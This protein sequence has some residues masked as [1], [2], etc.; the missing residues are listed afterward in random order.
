MSHPTCSKNKRTKIPGWSEHVKPLREDAMFWHSIWISSGSPSTGTV[1]VIRRRTRALYH[2]AIRTV[3]KHSTY[4]AANDIAQSHIDMDY[5][6]SRPA[7]LICF[8][9]LSPQ[10]QCMSHCSSYWPLTFGLAPRST[11]VHSSREWNFFSS[12]K[13]QWLNT[14]HVLVK[15]ICSEEWRTSSKAWNSKYAPRNGEQV[16]RHGTT[17]I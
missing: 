3:K 1:A 4:Y 11:Q 12:N 7:L 16:P 9:S 15:S 17:H 6:C 10:Q 2:R 14:Q 5:K 13:W 8:G